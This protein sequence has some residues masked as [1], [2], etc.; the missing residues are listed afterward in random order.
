MKFVH[1]AALVV[2]A[3]GVACTSTTCINPGPETWSYGN[4]TGK[5]GRAHV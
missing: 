2:A 1:A 5:I 3:A 4:A